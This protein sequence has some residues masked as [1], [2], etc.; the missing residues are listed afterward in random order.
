M[1]TWENVLLGIGAIVIVMLF[2]PGARAALE[3]SRNAENPDWKGALIPIGVVIL[4]II[5]LVMITRS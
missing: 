5:L 3:M 2:W 1:A 4:F